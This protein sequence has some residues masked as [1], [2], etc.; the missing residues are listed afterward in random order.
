MNAPPLGPR[1]LTAGATNTAA[2][3]APPT[4]KAPR[5]MC[6]TRRIIMMKSAIWFLLG[7]EVSAETASAYG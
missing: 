1:F 6:R 3:M 4:Q 5:R 7:A 2:V